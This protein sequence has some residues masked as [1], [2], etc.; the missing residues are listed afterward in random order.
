M[1]R[2]LKLFALLGC[3]LCI[4]AV[5]AATEDRLLQLEADMLKYMET[6]ERDKFFDITNRLKAGS[7]E[8]GNERLFY[9]AWGN[10]GIYEADQQYYE[11]AHEIARQMKDYAR[12]EGSIYGEYAAMHAEAMT[13][14]QE[15]SYDEAQRAFLDAMDFRHRHFP[16]ESAA[17]DLRELMKIA[18]YRN[19]IAM[20]KNYANQ[21][22]AEPNLAPHHKGRTLT[23][24]STMAFEEN[25]AE[26]FNHIYDEM[27]KLMQTDNISTISLYTEVNYHIINGNYKQALMLVDRLAADTCAERKALIYHRLGD[28]EKAYEYMVQYKNISD[29]LTRASHQNSMAS[30]YLRMNND[31]LR[32]EQ[33]VL[34]HKNSQLRYRFYIAVTT[35]LIMVLLFFIYKR[36]RIIKV[37][38][39][40][41]TM[42]DYGRKGAERALKEINELS[43][44]ESKANL[45][46]DMPV[47]VNKL[48]DY[49]ADIT[50]DHCNRGVST[51][52]Q[53][54][55]ADDF[56]I[57]T[58]AQALEKLLMH[59][60]NSSSTY[61]VKGIILLRCAQSG[62]MIMFSVTDTSK[63]LD[64]A[65]S[66]ASAVFAEQEDTTRNISMNFNICQSISRLLHGRI[67]HDTTYSEGTRFFFEIPQSAEVAP[68]A[69]TAHAS[70]Q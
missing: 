35:I 50:Q 9:Q 4:T 3:I 5:R 46:L 29:S 60:L 41:N 63:V 10:Q 36:R 58:N 42:L 8:A 31:H 33:E 62:D 30:L 44:Y 24:L 1:I 25:N 7:V 20:A 43:F 18:Y 14:L 23:R 70:H 53:T 22:L 69:A 40:H 13:L 34:A 17:E 37:L 57:T 48:C 55:F 27:K 64:D 65:K 47:K 49:L 6:K 15:G 28:N 26:E 12:Q 19:D 52:F 16:N 38:Q 56:E 21:M 2:H 32:L 68:H 67:W 39:H 59:L 11:S 54:D 66:Q 51:V 45:P 61:T